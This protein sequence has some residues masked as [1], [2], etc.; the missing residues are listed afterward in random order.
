MNTT[1]VGYLISGHNTDLKRFNLFHILR[2]TS[3]NVDTDIEVCR[4]VE[5]TPKFVGDRCFS[6]V[7]CLRDSL[8]DYRRCIILAAVK[9]WNLTVETKPQLHDLFGNMI[10]DDETRRPW[11][12]CIPVSSS[13]DGGKTRK[14][15]RFETRFPKIRCTSVNHYIS[16]VGTMLLQTHAVNT[17]IKT[18]KFS[19][20]NGGD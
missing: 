19:K 8:R 20:G 17:S 9:A 5:F 10:L 6:G 3:T 4:V 1:Q 15:P 13:K 11:K 16:I 12:W 14:W 18:T 2:T 7:Y